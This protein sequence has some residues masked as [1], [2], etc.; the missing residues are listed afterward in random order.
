LTLDP[1]G[2]KVLSINYSHCGVVGTSRNISIKDA[3]NKLIKEWHFV[4]SKSPMTCTVKDIAALQK[5]NAALS[6]YYT[7][8]E[9]PKGKL[10]VTL[11]LPQG[12]N[13]AL[14]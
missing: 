3:Q 6:L 13:T 12:V 9:I 14:N 11:V 1:R 4:D 7:S 8:R 5:S 2:Q 10:L